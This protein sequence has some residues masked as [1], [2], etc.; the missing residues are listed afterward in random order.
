MT[1]ITDKKAIKRAGSYQPPISATAVPRS[2]YTLTSFPR[3]GLW[4]GIGGALALL[5]GIT[6][7]WRAPLQELMRVLGDQAVVSAQI[8]SYG[9]WGPFVLALG[10]LVQVLIAFI[11]GHV[12]LAAAG[13]V[14]GFPLGLLLNIICIIAASQTA[15]LLARW[16]GRPFINR[17]ISPQLLDHWYEIGEKQGFLFFTVCF[18]LPVFPTDM[19]N[20]VA[21]L[22]GI[23]SRK[24]LA[25]SFFGRLPG[26]VMLT[27]IGSHGLKFSRIT[28][29]GLGVLV[30]AVYVIGRLVLLKIEQR[31]RTNKQST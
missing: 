19:M 14:Y 13:Y 11:P 6:W 20:F 2:S 24:F 21:G 18:I 23:S 29:I 3:L 10:Q 5:L 8:Q 12:L 28:W 27:L 30:T 4:M 25:A 9:I 1:I 16:L 17:L 7:E 26:I 22:S 15:F 31:Y